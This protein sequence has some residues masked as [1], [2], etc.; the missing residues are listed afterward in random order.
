MDKGVNHGRILLVEGN[1]TISDNNEISEKLNS[2]FADVVKNL[3][4]QQYR[5]ASNKRRGRLLNFLRKSEG[6]LF[7]GAFIKKIRFKANILFF[8][9]IKISKI[10]IIMNN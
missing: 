9:A 2:L 4:I 8:L 10:T 3:N 5:N 1:E 6:R 7:E